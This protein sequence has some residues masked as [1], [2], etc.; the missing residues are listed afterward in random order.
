[1]TAQDRKPIKSFRDLEV[2]Q[3][4]YRCCISVMKQIVPKLPEREK[5]DLADQLSRA[6]KAA[7][8]LVAE[9]YAKK[10]Q[11]SGFQKYLDDAMAECN[12][13]IVCLEQIKDIYHL[14]NDL[15][16]Q[17][18][19]DY[20]KSARQLYKLAEAWDKFKNTRRNPLPI[21]DAG[22]DNKSL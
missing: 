12:E 8:R 17:L 16:Q 11:R 4:L 18:I 19:D 20:D 5:Y 9:G 3:N 22:R 1:M 7:P 15:C 6:S 2:Y 21:T 13:V 14:E 10:H